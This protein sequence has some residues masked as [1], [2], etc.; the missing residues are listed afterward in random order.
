MLNQWV[1]SPPNLT[2]SWNHKLLW[3]LK[4]IMLLGFIIFLLYCYKFS[5]DLVT[6]TSCFHSTSFVYVCGKGCLMNVFNELEVYSVDTN[7]KKRDFVLL[8]LWSVELCILLPALHCLENV[9]IEVTLTR[10]A[11]PVTMCWT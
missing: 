4:K 11:I 9:K 2:F 6:L 5:F 8:N 3:P 1:V 7:A 10:E